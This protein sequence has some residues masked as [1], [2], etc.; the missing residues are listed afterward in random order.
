MR[1]PS[2]LW[3]QPSRF[4]QGNAVGAGE[5]LA[6]KQA[7]HTVALLRVVAC[8][9]AGGA[10][11]ARHY[12]RPRTAAAAIGVRECSYDSRGLTG[13]Q[14]QGCMKRMRRRNERRGEGQAAITRA[15]PGER[16]GRRSAGQVGRC[17]WQRLCH[18]RLLSFSFLDS[19]PLSCWSRNFKFAPQ[20][21]HTREKRAIGG[22]TATHTR[23]T[24]AGHT[25][26][27]QPVS[28]PARTK[29]TLFALPEDARE[30]RRLTVPGGRRVAPPASRRAPG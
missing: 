12:A 7:G 1:H 8:T 18:T 10:P 24:R 14:P 16:E 20:R 23:R 17:S 22:G 30:R 28:E 11:C 3:R 25:L 4:P 6:G 5:A 19:T 2:H 21:P 27:P 13:K 26:P 29:E 9:G 15:S